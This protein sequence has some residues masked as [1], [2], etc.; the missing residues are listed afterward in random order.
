MLVGSRAFVGYSERLDANDNN[1]VYLACDDMGL[2]VADVSDPTNPQLIA[3]VETPSL[4]H[5]VHAA[6]PYVYVADE[7]SGVLVFDMTIP[8]EPQ[9]VGA[10]GTERAGAL[11]ADDSYVYT[12]HWS[13]GLRIAA[14]QCGAINVQ[15]G[16]P[17][18]PDL[19]MVVHPNP[20]NPLTRIS[21]T[22]KRAGR[23]KMGV[24]DLGGRRVRV[25]AQRAFDAGHHS[26]DWNGCDSWG[27]AMPSGPYF[28]RLESE[29]GTETKKVM[30]VR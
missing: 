5:D 27:R 23:A 7:L 1:H 12:G 6:G 20:F 14:A 29:T 17:Q 4:T 16:V 8:S 19:A 11:F 25:L 13:G 2:Y 28:I 21:F 18:V 9:M 3:N 10:W 22:L 30:L 15:V 24:Y 26:L